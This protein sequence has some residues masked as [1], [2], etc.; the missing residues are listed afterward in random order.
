V[1]PSVVTSEAEP[2][3]QSETRQLIWYYGMSSFAEL[4]CRPPITFDY[5]INPQLRGRQPM[6][7]LCT[8]LAV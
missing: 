6:G 3:N 1:A 8:Q 7:S 2:D 5:L 4:L